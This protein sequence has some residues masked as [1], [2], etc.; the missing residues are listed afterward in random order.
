MQKVVHMDVKGRAI[1]GVEYKN[2]DFA[3]VKYANGK[4]ELIPIIR[5]LEGILKGKIDSKKMEEEIRKLRRQW[6]I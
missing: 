3:M 1:F 2:K 5:N 4:I 6:T